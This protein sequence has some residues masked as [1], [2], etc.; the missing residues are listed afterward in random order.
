MLKENIL[1][2]LE[3]SKFTFGKIKEYLISSDKYLNLKYKNINSHI[4]YKANDLNLN[5]LK[6]IL[7]RCNKLL[8]TKNFNIYII[9]CSDKRKLPIN[10][11]H[12]KPQNINGG[13]TS[14]NGNDIFIIR[15]EEYPKVILHE[16]THHIINII[17]S[18]ENIS[19]L[20]KHFNISEK[21]NLIPNEAIV[22]YMATIYYLKC[23]S[24]EKKININKLIKEELKYSLYKSYQLLELNKNKKWYEETNAYCYIIFKTILL[25]N[26]KKFMEKIKYEINDNII[27]EFL[28]K[29]SKLP[30][31]KKN[32]SSK[33]ANNS[34]RIM[35]NSDI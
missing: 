5:K 18:S 23:I 35:I 14:L 7:K 28:I 6:N 20:K 21:T 4:Y 24:N 11:E 32:P 33:I 30:I 22:E 31:I 13:Y 1:K 2:E 27:T 15:K 12:I 34:L 9:L 3:E 25:K 19:K 17:W 8:P 16:I 10:G 29:N 26:H